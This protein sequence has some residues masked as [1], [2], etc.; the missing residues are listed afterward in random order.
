[1]NQRFYSISDDV[2]TLFPHYLRGVVLARGV[3]NGPSP[4]P[5]VDMLR[6]AER[7]LRERLPAAGLTSHP[8]IHAWREAY[9]ASGIKP[10]EYRPSVEAMSRRVLRGESLPVINALVDLG[11]LLSLRHLIPVGGHAIDVLSGDIALRRATG[12]E[13]FCPFGSDLVEH[14]QPGEIIFAEG[15]IV[16]TRRWTWRQ[17]NHTLVQATTQELEINLDGLPPASAATIEAACRETAELVKTF[18]GGEIS[19]E[20]L[21]KEKTQMHWEI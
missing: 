19:W 18:C 11:N 3:R 14:P 4:E 12:Q 2:F 6:Q 1:M 13:E 17:A 10:G 5:L 8:H 20:I 21:S 16:L 7:A 9:R 15:M